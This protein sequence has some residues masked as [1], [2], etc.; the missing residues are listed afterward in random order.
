M[1]IFR[2]IRWGFSTKQLSLQLALGEFG[3]VDFSSQEIMLPK[4]A[5]KRNEGAVQGDYV[6]VGELS[7]FYIDICTMQLWLNMIFGDISV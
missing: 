7:H 1:T 2:A 4:G 3:W 5:T 6:K